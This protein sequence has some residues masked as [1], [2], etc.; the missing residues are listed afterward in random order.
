ML[1][2]DWLELLHPL[3]ILSCPVNVENIYL[4]AYWVSIHPVLKLVQV[5]RFFG[6]VY[7]NLKGIQNS[8]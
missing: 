4:M 3:F 8:R 2:G 1:M 7:A 6:L 5:C